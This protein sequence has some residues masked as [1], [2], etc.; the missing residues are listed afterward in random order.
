MTTVPFS[1][2][3]VDDQGSR[4]WSLS[5][6][7]ES[8]G[9]AVVQAGTGAQAMAALD[10]SLPHFLVAQ[11]QFADMSGVELCR[12]LRNR[13]GDTYI[14]SVLA[15]AET[16][17]N[18]LT[19]ALHAGVDDFLNSP[20]VHGELL[21]RLRAGARMWEYERRL[22]ENT[23][24]DPLTQLATRQAWLR[25]WRERMSE[26]HASRGEFSCV[27]VDLDF[28]GGVNVLHGRPTGDVVLKG[29]A[30]RLCQLSGDAALVGRLH[31]DRFCVLRPGATEAQACEWAK[32]ACAALQDA[33]LTVSGKQVHL[34]A[35]FGVAELHSRE[36][37]G[38]CLAIADQSLQI[39]K[40]TGRNR[41]VASSASKD[42]I[43][44]EKA[45]HGATDPLKNSV[46]R[47]IMTSAVVTFHEREPICMAAEL[48]DQ[49]RQS[50]LPVVDGDG[51]LLG[52]VSQA[53]VQARLAVDL[54]CNR[55]VREAMTTDVPQHEEDTTVQALYDFFREG[56]SGRVEI[57]AHGKPTGF[58]T[59][60]SLAALGEGI[61]R[62]SFLPTEA[63]SSAADWMLVP[64]LSWVEDAE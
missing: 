29:V 44:N 10:R 22:R 50:V 54:Y 4:I 45:D 53:D 52:T 46:A 58:V 21:S 37:P 2:L 40:Q 26:G 48:F 55:P 8:A 12:R 24:L 41:V 56:S 17:A 43:A 30:E 14:H 6:F 31:N 19:E 42:I 15:T 3:L 33:R 59:R 32:E 9:Y 61:S 63:D 5:S 34:T 18:A 27:V 35:S 11:W 62:E 60:G 38:G 47:D 49:C 28:F 51:K 39:A 57:V 23:P 25:R 13:G 1:I 36:T 64:D 7:L 20:I 16:N